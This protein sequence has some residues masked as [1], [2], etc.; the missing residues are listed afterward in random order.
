MPRGASKSTSID[1]AEGR[2]N[3]A[4]RSSLARERGGSLDLGDFH[5]VPL[6]SI[7]LQ[8]GPFATSRWIFPAIPWPGSSHES[9]H[10]EPEVVK[11]FHIVRLPASRTVD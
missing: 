9:S 3:V 8:P 2:P 6:R 10:L 4:R 1:L 7:D 5:G 11:T